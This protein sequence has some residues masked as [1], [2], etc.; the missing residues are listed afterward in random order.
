MKNLDIVFL[1]SFSP[2]IFLG[3]PNTIL[4]TGAIKVYA[5]KIKEVAAK[6]GNARIKV[7]ISLGGSAFGVREWVRMLFN[8]DYKSV[9]PPFSYVDGVYSDR[10]DPKTHKIKTDI[11]A[12]QEKYFPYRYKLFNSCAKFDDKNICQSR[13]PT[14]YCVGLRLHTKSTYSTTI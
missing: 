5:D 13:D 12:Q 7:L 14:S 10:W 8:Y 9:C 1:A 2:N 3:G 6:K 11:M 4:D